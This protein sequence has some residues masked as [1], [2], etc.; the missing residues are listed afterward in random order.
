MVRRSAELL[1][2]E[3]F[4]YADEAYL[5]LAGEVLPVHRVLVLLAH[6]VVNMDQR[7]GIVEADCLVLPWETVVADSVGQVFDQGKDQNLDL[8]VG[9][10]LGQDLDMVLDHLEGIAVDQT[11]TRNL[12]I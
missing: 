1:S 10:E 4:V 9:S 5:R 12:E 2:Q 3:I 7:M 6:S 11:E 8:G